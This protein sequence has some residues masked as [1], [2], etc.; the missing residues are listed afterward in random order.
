V[1][2]LG[3]ARLADEIP[4]P[5]AIS[6]VIPREEI[7]GAM[8]DAERSPEL[9]LDVDRRG[10]DGGTERSTIG[11]SWSRDELERLLEH[12]SG[13]SVLLTFDR[14]ELQF[15]FDDVE[16]HGLRE[17]TLVFAV[18]AMGAIGSGAAI[19]NAAPVLETGAAGPTS[20]AAIVSNAHTPGLQTGDVGSTATGSAVQVSAADSFVTDASSTGGYTAP[21]SAAGAGVVS[22]VHTPGLQLGPEGSAATG[23]AVQAPSADS[24]VTDASSTGGYTAAPASAADAGVVSNVHT[25]GLQLGAEGSAP[26]TRSVQAPGTSSSDEF[27]GVPNQD[28]T[29][30]LIAGGILLA[31]AGATFAGGRRMGTMRP[32]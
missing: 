2:T 23:A 1:A 7:V 15:A 28:I 6:A 16:A 19:A 10:E 13:D 25:P 29:D 24:F 32:A 12:S 22:N 18:A 5:R 26:A 21:A 31:I 11:I 4:A 9:Y 8:Q 17:R 20:S 30:G 14:D 3:T 27:L